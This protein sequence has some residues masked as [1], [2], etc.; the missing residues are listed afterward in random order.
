MQDKCFIKAESTF[1][2]CRQHYTNAIAV[3]SSDRQIRM[4][5][6]ICLNEIYFKFYFYLF[7]FFTI[8]DLQPQP[9]VTRYEAYHLFDF[10]SFTARIQRLSKV[11]R[12]I[13][14]I[15]IGNS[16][17]SYSQLLTDLYNRI[18]Y[19]VFIGKSSLRSIRI[20]PPVPT[21]VPVSLDKVVILFFLVILFE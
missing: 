10:N 11:S 19:K 4:N 2:L 7:F 18:K 5:G 17:L 8:Q 12:I 21:F 3:A 1:T 14:Q 15:N 16:K 20:K 13:L 6:E 9:C